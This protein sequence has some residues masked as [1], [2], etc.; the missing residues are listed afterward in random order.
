M[1]ASIIGF[2]QIQKIY[3]VFFLFCCALIRCEI[4]EAQAHKFEIQKGSFYYDDKPIQ[5]HSGEMH[6][7]RVPKEYWRHRLRMIKALGLNSVATY[8]FWNYHNISPGVWDFKTGNRDIA[9]F[10]RTAQEEGLFVIL[11]PGPYACAE[12]EFGGYPWWLQK[13]TSLIVRTYN[14]AFL[15]SCKVYIE[16]LAEQV[17]DLQ[18]T[19]GGP[20]IMV[21]AENEFG[22]YVSQRKDIPD[23]QHK[24][25]KQAIKQLLLDAGFDVT[26]FTSDGSWL[27][28][29]GSIEGVLPAAN[30]EENIDNLKRAV[31]QY[32]NNEGP[33]MVAEFYPGW[34]HHWAEPFPNID[35]SDV[36]KKL[37]KYLQNG[38]SFNIYMVHGGT[39]FGFTAGANYNEKHDIQPDLT[40]YD[41]DAPI[42]EAGWVSSKYLA[43][44]ELM[45]KYAGYSLPDIPASIPVINIPSIQLKQSVDLFSLKKNISPFLSDTIKTFEDINQGSGYVLYSKKF[46]QP[47]HGQLEI[48]GLRDFAV[49]Y[50]NGEKKGVLNRMDQKYIL[51]IEIPF[52][53]T[54][55]I[56]VENMGR[57]NYGAEIVH[58]KKGII[59]PVLINDMEVGGNWEMYPFPFTEMPVL[60]ESQSPAREGRPALYTGSFN[61]N[62]T[63]DVFLDLRIWGK[64]IVFVN[65]HNL[66]RYWNI[67]PQQTLYLPGTFLKK[68]KN[69]IVVFEQLNEKIKPL[70]STLS[71]PIL[72]DLRIKE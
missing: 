4:S 51:D 27:F 21:Q 17:K 54:L 63:G 70:V 9:A 59:S 22:S 36:V 12:W 38:I 52:N 3:L 14:K 65:G 25:Y 20:V 28:E 68:G 43:I 35:A 1:R 19:K 31:N 16:K 30:G 45:K 50:I 23:E 26:L 42:G 37:E 41:Y 57:I 18:V 46:T 39:N 61:L 10:I 13:D 2:I 34:L 32:H 5:I 53:G 47:M 33:Y 55:D 72:K 40:S 48:K 6:F 29:G 7:A 67:G 49:V 56:L 60:K 11:R 8:V 62:T 64:G 58:N 71:N 66:G 15:D 69:E 44:R 24:K